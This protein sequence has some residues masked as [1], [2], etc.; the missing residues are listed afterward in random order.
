MK[1]GIIG[2]RNHASKHID[3]LVNSK[4]VSKLLV[5]VYKVKIFNNLKTKIRSIIPVLLKI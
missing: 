1:I 4:L 5:F 2:Y 3:F